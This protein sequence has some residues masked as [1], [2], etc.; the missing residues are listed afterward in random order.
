MIQQI[1][2]K[3]TESADDDDN[4]ATKLSLNLKEK[5]LKVKGATD[6]I[7]TEA[8]GDTITVGLSDKVKKRVS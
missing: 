6:E 1:D 7:K 4:S 2:D 3:G 8:K 5:T